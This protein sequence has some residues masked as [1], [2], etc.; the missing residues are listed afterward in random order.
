MMVVADRQKVAREKL[1]IHAV[2]V[3]KGFPDN[4]RVVCVA[5]IGDESEE[6]VGLGMFVQ[7][8]EVVVTEQ[9]RDGS[10]R[11]RLRQ[12]FQAECAELRGVFNID[13]GV[14]SVDVADE[15]LLFRSKSCVLVDDAVLQLFF[16]KLQELDVFVV[17]RDTG[18]CL[19]S[20]A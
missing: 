5:C 15:L 17:L 3:D 10:W 6:L 8:G 16:P 19:V 12:V 2:G 14:D 1:G 11:Q 7:G 4:L 20:L 13:K 9:N 18:H